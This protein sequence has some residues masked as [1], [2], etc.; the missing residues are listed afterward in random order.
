MKKFILLTFSILLLFVFCAQAQT[1]TVENT[2][3]WRISGKGVKTSYLYGTMHVRDAR[4]FDFAD[5][6]LVAFGSCESYATEVH[7]D[8]L[9]QILFGTL[10]K[11][12]SKKFFDD[13]DDDDFINSLGKEKY[14]EI[15]RK[16]QRESGISLNQL[17][18]KNP[19]YIRS[20]LSEVE[21]EKDSKPVFLDL[22][23][24]DMAGGENKTVYGLESMQGTQKTLSALKLSTREH[25]EMEVGAI[26]KIRSMENLINYYHDNDLQAVEE[27]FNDTTLFDLQYRKVLLD[28]RNVIMA[29][30][31]DTI[32][33]QK[34]S[35]IAVGCAHLPGQYGLITLL[36]KMGFTVEPVMPA[37]TGKAA[38]YPI[39]LREL[40]WQDMKDTLSGYTISYPGKPYPVKV[41][42]TASDMYC[43]ND[44]G[45]GIVLFSYGIVSGKDDNSLSEKVLM[46][47]VKQKSGKILLKKNITVQKKE[48]LYAEL[49]MSGY[50]Y[51]IVL[52]NNEGVLYMLMGGAE[53]EQLTAGLFQKFVDSFRFSEMARKDWTDYSSE[54]DAFAVRFPGTPTMRE[55]D[56]SNMKVRMYLSS[57]Q[58]ANAAYIVQCMDL[59]N[60]KY[61]SDDSLMLKTI[62]DNVAAS[63]GKVKISSDRYG[64]IGDYPARF[65]DIETKSINYRFVNILRLNRIYNLI[66]TYSGAN[67]D[68]TDAFISSF[69]FA[70]FAEPQSH[71]ISDEGLPFSLSVPFKAD[72]DT[73]R[74]NDKG[75]LEEYSW[76]GNDENSSGL[77]MVNYR[78]YS[79]LYSLSD[80]AFQA[81]IKEMY[82]EENDSLVSEKKTEL[83]GAVRYDFMFDIP[84]SHVRKKTAHI[85]KGN[86]LLSTVVYYVPEQSTSPA[87]A[88]F[89]N[90]VTFNDKLITGNLFS[91]KKEALKKELTKPTLKAEEIKKSIETTEWKDEDSDFLVSLLSK[92]YEDDSLDYY[93]VK[94][95]LYAALKEIDHKKVTPKLQKMYQGLSNSDR[96]RALRYLASTKEMEALTFMKEALLNHSVSY[97]QAYEF[98]GLLYEFNDSV[99]LVQKIYPALLPLITDTFTCRSMYSTYRLALDSGWINLSDFSAYSSDIQKRFMEDINEVLAQKDV[100]PEAYIPYWLSNG[101][102]LVYALQLHNE[103]I[104]AKVKDVATSYSDD[105]FNYHMVKE[106]L[107]AGLPLEEKTKTSIFNNQFYQ[108]DMFFALYAKN[109]HQLL[110]AKYQDSLLLAESELFV[111]LNYE[112]EFTPD[113]MRFVKKKTIE[114]EGGQVDVYLFK[115]LVKDTDAKFWYYGIS[116]GYEKNNFRGGRKVY[117]TGM[118]WSTDKELKGLKEEEIIDR[119]VYPDKYY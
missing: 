19:R 109:K 31:I 110:P 20:L 84:S 114:Y 44:L 58:S 34:S 59:D 26:D 82:V 65:I 45:K 72:A 68:E 9:N 102:D 63:L 118:D 39:K 115:I 107:I 87:F 4:A 113:D 71:K 96:K 49:E 112:Y 111:E 12:L 56:A 6:V 3:L 51:K 1:S 97:S 46:R 66:I 69:S 40:E 61:N 91:D 25:Y 21:N 74:Y 16:M 50:Q 43:Y 32:I 117:L 5:S 75:V 11:K 23:L 10:E 7:P 104:N 119:L 93:S 28:N 64:S 79:S 99:E 52:L 54:R 88:D 89:V 18:S 70:P 27:L 22:Y 80:S 103:S 17:K 106:F 116:G 41:P 57:N 37:R 55:M 47:M 108:Y 98:S 86:V 83:T 13:Y 95:E 100:D 30:S 81:M 92:K 53:D 42:Y 67:K 60:G 94:T 77:Y 35:F 48:A 78:K 90:D 76:E 8:S 85:L 33:H 73:T 62:G 36:R 105:D 24:F 38:V 29:H 14:D 15:D 101:V 2:L